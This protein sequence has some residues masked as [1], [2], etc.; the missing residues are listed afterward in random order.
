MFFFS[1]SFETLYLGDVMHRERDRNTQRGEECR[2][3]KERGEIRMSYSF[4]PLPLVKGCGWMTYH[5]TVHTILVPMS[6][7]TN[8]RQCTRLRTDNDSVIE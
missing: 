3:E 8:K 6:K 4:R 1:N 5:L 7:K 2:R